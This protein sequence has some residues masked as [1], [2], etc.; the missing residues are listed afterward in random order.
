MAKGSTKRKR[1]QT[2][3]EKHFE[4]LLILFIII[5]VGT[6]VLWQWMKVHVWQSILVA[7]VIIG[8]FVLALSK[9]PKFREFM[10]GE[11]WMTL[12]NF[13][14]PPGESKRDKQIKGGKYRTPIPSRIKIQVRDRAADRCQRC[15]RFGK[16]THH[17]NRIPNDHKMS[18][19]ILLCPTCHDE[20]DRGHPSQERLRQLAK[21]Q[22]GSKTVH[23]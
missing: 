9:L 5:A 22:A 6:S 16:D 12:W 18:N 20:A 14:K 19:L 7:V 1:P 10:G 3:Q 13:L 23:Y 17:I 15:G 2:A 21:K 8:L 4:G 11:F